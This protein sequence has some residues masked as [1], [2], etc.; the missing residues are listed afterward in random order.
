MVKAIMNTEN[1][2][3]I[4]IEGSKEE[5]SEIIEYVLTREKRRSERLE[6]IMKMRERREKELKEKRNKFV[7]GTRTSI[8]EVLTNLIKE[9]FFDK[10]K[11]FREVRNCLEKEG[12]IIPSSTVHPILSRLVIHGKL[13][14]AKGEDDLWEYVKK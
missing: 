7:H 6:F 2:T 9:G 14:R 5:V 12:L 8:T 1:G 11:K 13:K 3:E 4:I 10:S